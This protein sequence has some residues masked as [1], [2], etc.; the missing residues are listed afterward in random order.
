MRRLV[1]YEDDREFSKLLERRSDVDLA[2]VNLELSRDAY[3]ELNFTETL[4][5]ID[6]RGRELAVEMKSSDGDLTR[7]QRIANCLGNRHELRGS[8]QSF[9]SV[10]GSYLH[11]VIEQRHGLP[12]VMSILY[13]AVAE[14]VGINLH[15]V[16]APMHFLLG[17]MD[18]DEPLYIDPFAG[19]EVMSREDCLI[20]LSKRTNFAFEELEPYLRP[21]RPRDVV[22]RLLNNLKAMYAQEQNWEASFKV[23]QRLYS[24]EPADYAN[25]RDLGIVAF[26]AGKTGK[27][28]HLLKSCLAEA[29]E[30]E[31]VVLAGFLNQ[32]ERKLAE[33]N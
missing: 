23:Q 29:S 15:G 24:L 12:I 4:A 11:K 13:Q 8:V 30:K 2:V 6:Q 21:A 19:G 20:F 17:H 31:Q 26:H 25:R 3:P 7:L 16:A 28:W 9:Q 33:W 1:T 22:T 14:Q 27:A 5:W 10:D 18:G 32:A